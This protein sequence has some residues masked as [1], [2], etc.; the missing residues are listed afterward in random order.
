MKHVLQSGEI[1]TNKFGIET[2]L[3]YL[4]EA[5]HK[6][7][8]MRYIN[9]LCTSCNTEHIKQFASIKAGTITS[10][11]NKL[12][13]ISTTSLHKIKYRKGD[14]VTNSLMYLEEDKQRTTSNHRYFKVQCLCGEIF[15]IRV[16]HKNKTCKKCFLKQKR[17]LITESNKAALV[18][19]LFQSYKRNAN[20]RGYSFS[21]SYLFFEKLI[22]KN[23]YYC[24]IA[25]NN[26]LNSGY[27]FMYYNGIDRKDNSI[28]YKSNNCVACCGKCNMM[29]NKW[30]HDDFLNHIKSIINNL[31]L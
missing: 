1:I 28:G 26:K 30:S 23:C 24:G 11:G 27:K 7:K 20:A 10:C 6:G 14:A 12:C 4:S 5:G 18:N 31:N 17:E 16:D 2:K 25:P 3:Q 9:V 19:N 21:L 22:K 15:S 13:K 29:K 8:G